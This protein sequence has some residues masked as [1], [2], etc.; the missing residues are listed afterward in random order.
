VSTIGDPLSRILSEINIDALN[1]GKSVILLQVLFD[2]ET[3]QFKTGTLPYS[4]CRVTI[5]NI[6]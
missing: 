5:R 3:F 6:K 4:I 1:S 2:A